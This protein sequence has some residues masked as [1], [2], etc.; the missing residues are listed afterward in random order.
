MPSDNKF[1]QASDKEA[2]AEQVVM[3]RRT[4]SHVLESLSIND[5]QRQFPENWYVYPFPP[6][7][8]GIDGEVE[9]FRSDGYATGKRFHVQYKATDGDEIGDKLVIKVA[10]LNYWMA[11]PMPVMVLRWYA[12][13]KAIRW[14]WAH[15]LRPLPKQMSQETITLSVAGFNEWT[16]ETSTQIENLVIAMASARTQ[17]TPPPWVI[18]F[19]LKTT[20]DLAGIAKTL[21]TEMYNVLISAG[22]PIVRIGTGAKPTLRIE[23]END[24]FIVSFATLPGIVIHL[25]EDSW[26]EAAQN[27]QPFQS[28]LSAAV[29]LACVRFRDFEYLDALFNALAS[30][31]RTCPS[32]ELSHAVLLGL[33]QTKGL[34]EAITAAKKFDFWMIDRSGWP[35]LFLGMLRRRANTPADREAVIAACKALA[36]DEENPETKG[37]LLYNVGSGLL[38]VGRWEEALK[39]LISSAELDRTYLQR[40]Y[41]QFEKGVSHFQLRDYE[42]ALKAYEEAQ[43]LDP[44]RSY[45]EAIGDC[46]FRLGKLKQSLDAFEEYF[47]SST[48]KHSP[49]DMMFW[50]TYQGVRFM[51]ETLGTVECATTGPEMPHIP[52]DSS[53]SYNVARTQ[54]LETVHI[55]PFDGSV[56]F[57][58]GHLANI[59]A[60]P[61]TACQAYLAAAALNSQ[62]HE[63]WGMAYLIALESHLVDQIA[64]IPY[65][66]ILA[67]SAKF[68]EFVE[69]Q[70]A[71]GLPI[72]VS[73]KVIRTVKESFAKVAQEI[74][75]SKSAFTVRRISSSEQS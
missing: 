68:E 38:H 42:S 26:A 3:P 24:W 29:F 30:Q 61:E 53:A 59:N 54:Y 50:C 37:L 65:G 69:R 8:Y 63:A 31:L 9:I 32:P 46:L 62:D 35:S 52:P 2:S 1:N 70:L 13:T 39:T 14:I 71:K 4:R 49:R 27:A 66:A 74:A 72:E 17:R 44:E 58:L 20:P 12:Q 25:S 41:F 33:A 45:R 60:Q 55:A 56:W 19:A 67:C 11:S 6:P 48:F 34:L 10:T 15:S 47:S 22:L 75:T 36:E 16:T 21:E 18:E 28:I 23:I 57:N 73:P 5:I 64:G 40:P 51:Y 7:E 43:R